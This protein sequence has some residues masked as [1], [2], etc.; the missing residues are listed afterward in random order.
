MSE[1]LM[2]GDDYWRREIARLQKENS[3]LREQLYKYAD[4]L[5]SHQNTNW[6]VQELMKRCRRKESNFS[7]LVVYQEP[8]EVYDWTMTIQ[9]GVA[10]HRIK[11]EEVKVCF[12]Y[13]RFEQ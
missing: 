4:E 2:S 13:S 8:K 12:Y 5:V 1:E 9:P 10:P 6:L 11:L 3:V 7:E